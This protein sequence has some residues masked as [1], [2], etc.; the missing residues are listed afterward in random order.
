MESN[1]VDAEKTKTIMRLWG[2]VG[3]FSRG[4]GLVNRK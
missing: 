3:R 4:K 1:R 2:V